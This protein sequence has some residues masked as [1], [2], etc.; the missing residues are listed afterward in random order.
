M[1]IGSSAATNRDEVGRRESD[2]QPRKRR[3]DRTISPGRSSLRELWLAD[4]RSETKAARASFD[5]PGRDC[6]AHA[7]GSRRCVMGSPRALPHDSV[8][9]RSGAPLPVCALEAYASRNPPTLLAALGQSLCPVCSSEFPGRGIRTQRAVIPVRVCNHYL[10]VSPFRSSRGLPLNRLS[11][12]TQQ[13]SNP[14]PPACKAGALPDELCA[15]T[16]TISSRRRSIARPGRQ[17]TGV[18]EPGLRSP[19]A[20][21]LH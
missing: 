4:K 1:V 12:W 3:P 17:F 16:P 14:P 13:D 10:G 11:G 5:V 19:G 21:W 2:G 9:G 18:C 15:Q 7:A 6:I 8:A 20:C